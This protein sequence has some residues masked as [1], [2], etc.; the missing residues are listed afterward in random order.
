MEPIAEKM[1]LP[2]N[3]SNPVAVLSFTLKLQRKVT[4]SSY[5]LTLPCIFLASLT[6]VVFWLP[7]D[8]PDR[9]G[10]GIHRFY[11][12]KMGLWVLKWVHR[13]LL[14]LSTRIFVERHYFEQIGRNLS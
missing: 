5:M 1:R 13:F 9:T 2:E 8:R 14:L 3:D 12:L 10:L 6:L 7:P 4:F 11:F